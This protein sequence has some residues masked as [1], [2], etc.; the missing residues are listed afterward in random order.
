MADSQSQSELE[1]E[2]SFERKISQDFDTDGRS[3]FRHQLFGQ[4]T[5]NCKI[6]SAVSEQCPVSFTPPLHSFLSQTLCVT[7][8]RLVT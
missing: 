8:V 3:G 7:L 5:T 6:K 1:K 4:G 2:M